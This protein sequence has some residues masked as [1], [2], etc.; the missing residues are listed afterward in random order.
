[1]KTKSLKFNLIQE[2]KE[3]SRTYLLNSVVA[4]KSSTSP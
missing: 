4:M 2:K 1:M 3:G